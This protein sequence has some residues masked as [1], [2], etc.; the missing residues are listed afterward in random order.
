M[1]QQV[2]SC[3]KLQVFYLDV[4]YIFTHMSQI[5][6]PDVSSRH[7]LHL[8]VSCCTCLMLFGGQGAGGSDGG[9]TRTSG[10]GGKFLG[11]RWFGP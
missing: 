1:L 4:E 9:T 8:S 10:N 11:D 3:C 2:F 6:V 5:N 7:I